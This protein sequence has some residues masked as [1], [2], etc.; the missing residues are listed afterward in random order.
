MKLNPLVQQGYT[1][2][3]MLIVLVL[4]VII[5]VPLYQALSETMLVKKNTNAMNDL[6]QQSRFAL[7]QLETF[8][9]ALPKT[10]I[11]S[12]TP[13]N[14]ITGSSSIMLCP[15]T[16]QLISSVSGNC[17]NADNVVLASSVATFTAQRLTPP[18]NVV[19]EKTLIGIK[20][21]LQETNG[22]NSVDVTAKFIQGGP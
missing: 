20:L 4:S 16:S 6:Q 5:I 12:T 7:S 10:A 15:S 8:I 21:V 22:P 14:K 3:E 11:V 17:G 2:V 19:Y 9:T 13:F 1:L 18:P